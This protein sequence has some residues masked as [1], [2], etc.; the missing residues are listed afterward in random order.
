MTDYFTEHEELLENKLGITDP[1][2]LKE[3]ESQICYLRQIEI[4]AELVPEKL[5]FDCFLALHKRLFGDLYEFAGKVR[6]VDLG[7]A[8]SVFCYV[9]HINSE[10]QRIFSELDKEDYLTGLAQERFAERVAYYASELNALHP[11]RD[12]NGRTI[13]LFLGLLSRKAGYSIQY[14]LCSIKELI[15]ADVSGFNGNL[16]P[17]IQMYQSI[18]Q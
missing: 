5:D 17:L 3:A 16:Q 18:I 1:D 6:T 13:R 15:E 11:F 12:G 14:H 9:Q 4:E 7:K 10:Q 8:G 2:E